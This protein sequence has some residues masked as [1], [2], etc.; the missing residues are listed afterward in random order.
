MQFKLSFGEFAVNQNMAFTERQTIGREKVHMHL[1]EF[2]H[3]GLK[4][5]VHIGP[6]DNK[7]SL[8]VSSRNL[9]QWLPDLWRHIA[10][11]GHNK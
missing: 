9:N 6:T 11:Q 5:F 2:V 4:E 7:Y 3:I 8:T 1:K 10:L